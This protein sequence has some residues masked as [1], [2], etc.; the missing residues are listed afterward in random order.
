[1][2][3]DRMTLPWR[4]DSPESAQ[5]SPWL[6]FHLKASPWLGIRVVLLGG[7]V[8]FLLPF[9]FPQQWGR[10]RGIHHGLFHPPAGGNHLHSF[11]LRAG[12]GEGW[13]YAEDAGPEGWWAAGWS[14]LGD[15]AALG[16]EAGEGFPHNRPRHW[17]AGSRQDGV[18]EGGERHTTA[19]I[20][21]LL[22]GT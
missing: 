12:L 3:A 4:V 20:P 8:H 10:P 9:P 14:R 1:M 21:F 13:A 7:E 18:P 17:E 16:C 5:G 15:A 2:C 19:E 6:P 11:P 22:T